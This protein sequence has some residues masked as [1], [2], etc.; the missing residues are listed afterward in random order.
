MSPSGV[1][2]R[3]PV[4]YKMCRTP[5]TAH[6][7]K[8]SPQLKEGR[9]AGAAEMLEEKKGVRV[10]SLSEGPRVFTENFQKC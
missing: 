10:S 8:G 9:A 4:R 1:S 7:G 3:G 2:G 5:L 6:R